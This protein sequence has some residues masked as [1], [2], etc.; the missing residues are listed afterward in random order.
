LGA[1]TEV[2]QVYGL[3]SGKVTINSTGLYIC[4]DGSSIDTAAKVFHFG[5]N[6]L[7]YNSTGVNGTWKTILDSNGNVTT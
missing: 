5:S 1:S 4:V 7:R 3:I 6:G 2:K